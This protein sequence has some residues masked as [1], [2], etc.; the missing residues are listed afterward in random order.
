MII[1]IC[2]QLVCDIFPPSPVCCRGSDFLFFSQSPRVRP[3]RDECDTTSVNRSHQSSVIIDQWD[4]T[5]SSSGGSNG[6]R[7]V[8]EIA[9]TKK[10]KLG[11]LSALDE[12]FQA[13]SCSRPA[14]TFARSPPTAGVTV[15]FLNRR[16]CHGSLSQ[17]TKQ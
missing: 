9:R 16:R 15:V 6:G 12:N 4:S 11:E 8:G 3:S 10:C 17:L 1:V 7:R 5:S 2:D 13:V 14:G